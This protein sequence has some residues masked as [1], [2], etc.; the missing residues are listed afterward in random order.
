MKSNSG[1]LVS[2]LISVF[3]LMPAFSACKARVKTEPDSE[4][5]TETEYGNITGTETEAVFHKIEK[6]MTVEQVNDIIGFPGEQTEVDGEYDWLDI[7]NST[8]IWVN[9]P[10]SIEVIFQDGRAVI[11]GLFDDG[12][13][14][15][16][17][18]WLYGT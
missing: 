2:M 5:N 4:V 9:S 7:P 16:S 14:I 11:S 17:N 1:L 18:S 8:Y 13:F 3:V 15:I 10:M 6:D 12:D